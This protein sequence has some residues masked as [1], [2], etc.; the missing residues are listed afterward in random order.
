MKVRHMLG[1]GLVLYV[2]SCGETK[3]KIADGSNPSATIKASG[4]ILEKVRSRSSGVPDAVLNLTRCI[5]IVPQATATVREGVVDCREAHDRW[6]APRSVSLAVRGAAGGPLGD[7][8][9]FVIGEAAV[10]G[11]A[12]GRLPLNTANAGPGPTLQD[13]VTVTDADLRHEVLLYQLTVNKLE[14][15]RFEGEIRLGA[16]APQ[17]SPFTEVV[18]AFFNAITPVGIIVHHSATLGQ[19]PSLP[20]SVRDVDRFHS[21]KGFEIVCD[22]KRFHVAYH[23]LILPDGKIQRGRPE[24]CEG[25]HSAG[26][27]SYLGI[28]IV[29][30][31]SSKD[32]PHGKKGLIQP[33]PRQMTSLAKLSRELMSRYRIPLNRVL[34]HSDVATTEC[35][36]DRFPFRAFLRELQ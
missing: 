29:G 8:L 36:G 13:A 35:P 25:A 12:T 23:F 20:N 32:N 11:L 27:N 3:D 1:V 18:T 34:R 28:S 19:E 31:F 6:L 4:A 21:E 14:A 10:R 17:K 5:V 30:D 24:R 16:P 26:Y 15:V 7:V 22:G 9:I 33:T 2:C